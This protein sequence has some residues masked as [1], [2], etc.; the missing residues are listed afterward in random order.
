MAKIFLDTNILLDIVLKREKHQQAKDLL[1]LSVDG[2]IDL[3]FTES[4]LINTV[5]IANKEIKA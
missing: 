5:F 4:S 3:Y 1:K 2:S